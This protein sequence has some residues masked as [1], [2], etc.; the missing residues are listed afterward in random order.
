MGLEGIRKL[1]GCPRKASL[2]TTLPRLSAEQGDSG[3]SRI[4]GSGGSTG[5]G[6]P[7]PRPRNGEPCRFLTLQA[8]GD[9]QQRPTPVPDTAH[10]TV[11]GLYEG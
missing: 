6:S 7:S 2:A 8:M 4:G 9:G 11:Q 3:S 10:V 5:I 1:G